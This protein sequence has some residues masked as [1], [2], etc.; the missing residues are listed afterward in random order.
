[1]L[2][3]T[4]IGGISFLLISSL[5]VVASS[6]GRTGRT[7][8][9]DTPGCTCHGA[10]ASTNVT[11]LI[12]GPDSIEINSTTTYQ[13]RISGGPAAAAGTNIAVSDGALAPISSNLQLS[14]GELIH[15]SPVSFGTGSEVVFEFE[16]TAPGQSGD[17]TLAANGNSVNL[18]GNTSGDEWNFAP[19]KI[20]S[21][22]N[23]S[24]IVDQLDR[25][26]KSFVLQQNYPNP[27]NPKTVISYQ[28]SVHSQVSLNIYNI[29]G[30]R[31]STL[32]DRPQSAGSYS[33][34][35]EA[36]N[37]PSG[38]YFYTLRAGSKV[39]SKRMVLKK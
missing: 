15:T 5:F 26:P 1:M 35:F 10:T 11:V 17:V 22:V 37:L 38:T 29:I 33:V 9:S 34:N 39:Q 19:D 36:N 12:D 25:S 20:I 14:G 4:I 28:L 16:Y 13:V 24:A 30:Q 7:N 8:L 2:R 31:I 6:A 21:V 27:F 3:K 23:T 32:V 18:S